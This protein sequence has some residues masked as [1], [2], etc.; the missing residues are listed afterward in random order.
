MRGVN[1]AHIGGTDSVVIGD[2]T[3]NYVNNTGGVNV[4]VIHENK[5]ERAEYL[6]LGGDINVYRRRRD[7]VSGDD[8][9]SSEND[10]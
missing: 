5:V 4:G 10:V 9:G 8:D 6:A 3:Q 1:T 7:G 2:V